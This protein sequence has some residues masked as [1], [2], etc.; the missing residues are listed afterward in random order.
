[1]DLINLILFVVVANTIPF[2]G[3]ASLKQNVILIIASVFLGFDQ[4][5]TILWLNGSIHV[6]GEVSGQ[7]IFYSNTITP[8]IALGVLDKTTQLSSS[9]KFIAINNSENAMYLYM[10]FIHMDVNDVRVFIDGVFAKWDPDLRCFKA[11]LDAK[12]VTPRT[13]NNSLIENKFSGVT[14][15]VRT[16]GVPIKHLMYV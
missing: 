8:D 16:N 6:S 11:L 3:I 10:D 7:S 4:T 1:M 15:E 5:H 14:F 2:T 12:D 9:S 13:D